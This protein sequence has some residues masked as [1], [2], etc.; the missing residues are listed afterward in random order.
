MREERLRS[1]NRLLLPFLR[2]AR[3]QRRLLRL[4][5]R[6]PTRVLHVDQSR[7]YTVTVIVYT[8]PL[9]N[10]LVAAIYTSAQRSRPLSPSQLRQRLQRLRDTVAKLRGRLYNQADIIYAVQV[11]AGATRGA[12]RLARSLG[13]NL[14]ENTEK[15]LAS[16][17]RYTATRYQRLAAKLRGKRVW[18]PVPL[19][20][21][22]LAHLAKELGAHDTDPPPL[23]VTVKLAQEGGTIPA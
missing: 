5:G 17:A 1:L 10:P 19:L 4:A 7:D 13:V 18:G 15:L 21:H 14:A 23:H 16:L 22:T 20:L 2:S 9:G 6:P 3:E 12:R 11:P 8:L